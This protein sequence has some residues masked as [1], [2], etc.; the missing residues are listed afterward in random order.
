MICVLQGFWPV[1]PFAGAEL[2]LLW[3]CFYHNAVKGLESDVIEIDEQSVA[4]E[5]SQRSRSRR[6]NLSRAWAKVSLEMAPARFHP[7]RLSLGSH[8]KYVQVGRFLTDEERRRVAR[9]LRKVLTTH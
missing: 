8:G 6:W 9:E 2:A 3:F 5:H 1:L 4:V 7:S